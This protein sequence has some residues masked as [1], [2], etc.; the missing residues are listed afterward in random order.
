M[1]DRF[2]RT[3][4]RTHTS[5]WPDRQFREMNCT[6]ILHSPGIFWYQRCHPDLFDDF[7]R[8]PVPAKRYHWDDYRIPDNVKD[9]LVK[10][11]EQN[12]RA[13]DIIL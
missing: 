10:A 3:Y 9:S 6:Q 8:L 4:Y 13:G 1:I 5:T 12:L 7:A 11:Y 2:P